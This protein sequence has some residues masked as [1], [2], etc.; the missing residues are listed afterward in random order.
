VWGHPANFE[1]ILRSYPTVTVQLA[2]LG[3]GA[4]ADVARLTSRYPNVVTDM[5]LRLG[6]EA[7]E[8]TVDIVRRIGAD[9]VLFGSN[10]PVVDQ[11]VYVEAFRALPLR[12]DEM[13]LVGHDNAARLLRC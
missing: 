4:E 11:I 12:P 6:V 7:P 2:H 10:Y 8:S 9:R 13:L 1:E 5:S 3:I